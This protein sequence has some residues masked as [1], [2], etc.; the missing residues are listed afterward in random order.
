MA[1][2]AALA[3]ILPPEDLAVLRRSLRTLAAMRAQDRH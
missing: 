3:R 1:F 2:D